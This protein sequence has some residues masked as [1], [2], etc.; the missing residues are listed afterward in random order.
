MEF[1]TLRAED[2]LAPDESLRA[3]KL[4]RYGSACDEVVWTTTVSHAL[5]KI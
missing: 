1:R 5:W 2:V 4:L 3:G